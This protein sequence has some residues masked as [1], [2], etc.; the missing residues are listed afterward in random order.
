MNDDINKKVEILTLERFGRA[1][2]FVIVLGIIILLALEILFHRHGE[3]AIEDYFFFP[4]IF[5]FVAFIFVVMIGA[6]LRRFIM[7][8]ED[9]YSKREGGNNDT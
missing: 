1:F 4:A 2:T 6:F 3:Y 5:G 8:D 9:Y 7:R